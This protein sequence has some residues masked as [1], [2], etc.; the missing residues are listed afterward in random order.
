M[1]HQP[2]LGCSREEQN[3]L[4]C[5]ESNQNLSFVVV[6]VGVCGKPQMYYS[7]LAYWTARFGRSNFDH[8][9]PSR[10]PTCSA[11]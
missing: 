4:F 6:V 7:L 9:M 2:D 11:L 8:Q 10:L 1:R 3:F 5:Q